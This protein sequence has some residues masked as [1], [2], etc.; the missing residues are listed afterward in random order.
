MV[1]NH[2]GSSQSNN[3]QFLRIDDANN[4]LTIRVDSCNIVARNESEVRNSCAYLDRS[5]VGIS[6]NQY[7]NRGLPVFRIKIERFAC[8]L[9]DFC[10]VFAIIEPKIGLGLC[11]CQKNDILDANNTHIS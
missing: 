9:H 6:C 11:L 1:K 3:I 5:F 7:L 8:F 2:L 10:I 4:I